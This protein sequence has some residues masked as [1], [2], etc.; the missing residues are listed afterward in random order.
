MALLAWN[1]R[2]LGNKDTVRALKNI[3]FKHKNDIVF[4]SETKQKRRYL[5]K[6]RMRM[7]MDNACY[8]DPVGIAGGLALWWSNN[9]KLSMLSHDKN[10]IDTVISI[11]GE[12]EWFGTF[13]YAPPYEEEK[14]EFWERLG[15]LRDDVNAKWCIMGDTNIVASPNEKYGGSPFDHNNAKWF[16]E[17]LEKAYLMEIQSKGGIYTWSNQ[18]CEE[19]EIREKLDRVLSSLEWSFLFPKAIAIV[20]IPVASDHAPIVLLTNGLKKR[21]RTEFKF[22]S[23]WTLEEECS[24]IVREEWKPTEMRNHRGTFRVNLRRTKVKLWKWSREKFGKNKTSAN[25]IVNKIQNLQNGPMTNDN[26][27]KNSEFTGRMVRR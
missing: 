12:D 26:A 24:N 5:E 7:K 13:I 19:N 1:V 18:R 10:L 6:I 21:T 16:H 27:Q 17:F 22:E 11:N 20:E 23:R 25:A 4:L 15:T 14:Q 9:V 8:V 3:C 2:G